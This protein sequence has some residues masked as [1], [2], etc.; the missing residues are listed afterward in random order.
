MANGKH[1]AAHPQPLPAS[2]IA[3]RRIISLP[4]PR[5]SS[6]SMDIQHQVCLYFCFWHYLSFLPS[7]YSSIKPT[8]PGSHCPS[9]ATKSCSRSR[10]LPEQRYSVATQSQGAAEF[11]LRRSRIRPGSTAGHL[12]PPGMTYACTF[13]PAMDSQH[14]KFTF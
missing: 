5:C 10:L 1:P 14:H 2:P 4:C 7:A 13:L 3:G 11:L 6:A 12:H 8:S 9:L